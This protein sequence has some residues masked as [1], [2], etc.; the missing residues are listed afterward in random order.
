M[1]CDNEIAASVRRAMR[2]FSVDEDSLA[3]PVIDKVMGGSRNFLA[4]Q[5]SIKYLRAG[6]IMF[7]QLGERRTFAEW[8]RSGRR[9]LAENA[10]AK[11]E[12]ILAEHEVPPLEDSQENELEKIMQAAT[13]EFGL[14]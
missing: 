2:G 12:R 5:H 10:Q 1:V 7:A 4:E 6:E 13:N 8:D 3:V 11:A 14:I 9:S